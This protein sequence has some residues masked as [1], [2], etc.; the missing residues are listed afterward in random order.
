MSPAKATYGA[1]EVPYNGKHLCIIATDGRLDGKGAY[2]TEWEHVSVHV[3][4]PVFKKNQTPTW[5]Q[6]AYAKSLFW[7]EDEVVMELHVASGDHINFHQHTLHLWRPTKASI[8]LPPKI[9]V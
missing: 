8:P 3:V 1:F 4:D 9:L 5:D 7:N 6:M 2:D